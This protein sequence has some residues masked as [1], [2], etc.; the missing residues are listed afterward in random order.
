MADA[1][2][3]PGVVPARGNDMRAFSTRSLRRTCTCAAVAA[4]LSAVL[5]IGSGPAVAEDDDEMPD[6]KVMRSIMRGLGLRKPGEEDH[7]EYRERSPLVVP[8]SR[9]L[10]P[11]ETAPLAARDPAWPDDPDVKARRE[12]KK[13][14]RKSIDVEEESRTLTPAE[15]NRKGAPRTASASGAPIKSGEEATN[16]VKPSEL[17]YSGGLFSWRSFL[18][19]EPKEEYGTFDKEP[20]RTELTQPP[21]GYLTPSPNQPYGVSKTIERPTKAKSYDQA[22]GNAEQR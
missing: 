17:G 9:D 1:R 15:L 20:K 2:V 13:H 3:T 19:A 12:A 18:G 14:A 22:A 5:V 6:V 4:A 10:P 11:P 8:P 7:I 21:P 16:Q